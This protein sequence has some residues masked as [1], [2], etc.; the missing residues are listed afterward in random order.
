MRESTAVA[1][2]GQVASKVSEVAK[3]A[4]HTVQGA[5]SVVCFCPTL[6]CPCCSPALPCI[7]DHQSKQS[8]A[9]IPLT[10]CSSNL[11]IKHNQSHLSDTH[12]ILEAFT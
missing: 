6:S 5:M 10:N 4:A 11:H 2:V 12:V 8:N 3:E 1:E 7:A 9:K